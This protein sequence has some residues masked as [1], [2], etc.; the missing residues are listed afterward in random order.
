VLQAST[1]SEAEGPTAVT[2]TSLIIVPHTLEIR[3]TELDHSAA[4]GIWPGVTPSLSVSE[5]SQ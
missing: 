2:V 3:E 5:R 4:R 1:N